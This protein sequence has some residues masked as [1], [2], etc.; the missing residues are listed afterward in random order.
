MAFPAAEP[1][2]SPTDE[3]VPPDKPPPNIA[4]MLLGFLRL[5]AESTVKSF[6]EV[7]FPPEVPEASACPPELQM[8][9]LPV[10]VALPSPDDFPV[11]PGRA[12]ALTPIFTCRR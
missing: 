12:L 1:E 6:E 7:E 8:K 11:P 5:L 4:S 10:P 2:S 9:A 3:S